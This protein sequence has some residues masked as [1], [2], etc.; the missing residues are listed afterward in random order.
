LK[1]PEKKSVVF[2]ISGGP[3]PRMDTH[4]FSGAISSFDLDEI[5]RIQNS[6]TF[7]CQPLDQIDALEDLRDY[8]VIFFHL[9]YPGTPKGMGG[10]TKLGEMKMREYF[11]GNIY[12]LPGWFIKD[13]NNRKLMHYH[14]I[15]RAL[16]WFQPLD[17]TPSD[18]V[19]TMKSYAI[20]NQ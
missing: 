7:W 3:A 4:L 16:Y 5:A 14:K 8:E 6:G 15:D 11:P 9:D 1:G 12:K 13:W 20:K 17:L 19:S 10:K 2:R 18:L